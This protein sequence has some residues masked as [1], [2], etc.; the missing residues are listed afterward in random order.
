MEQENFADELFSNSD[1]N[2]EKNVSNPLFSSK[3]IFF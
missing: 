3:Y 2:Q 1:E